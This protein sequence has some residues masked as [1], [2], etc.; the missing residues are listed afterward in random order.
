M[1]FVLKFDKNTCD[2]VTC[3]VSCDVS[4]DVCRVTGANSTD[5][6]FVAKM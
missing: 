4:D 2:V 3:D 1:K 5:I 6:A